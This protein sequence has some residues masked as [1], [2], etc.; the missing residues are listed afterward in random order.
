MVFPAQR[1]RARVLGNRSLEVWHPGEAVSTG[2]AVDLSIPGAAAKAVVEPLDGRSRQP[3]FVTAQEIQYFSLE[4]SVIACPVED[5]S[6][7][8]RIEL[9]V[10]AP[11]DLV[12][13]V[14]AV[15]QVEKVAK[16]FAASAVDRH[17]AVADTTGRLLDLRAVVENPVIAVSVSCKKIAA[18]GLDELRG[19]DD[20]PI[21]LVDDLQREALPP[22]DLCRKAD[23]PFPRP[24][25]NVKTGLHAVAAQISER[26]AR[27]IPSGEGAADS[28]AETARDIGEIAVEQRDAFPEQRVFPVRS[29]GADHRQRRTNDLQRVTSNDDR[30]LD[31]GELHFIEERLVAGDHATEHVFA[32]A[33]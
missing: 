21:I 19:R 9:A 12:D 3:A 10:E 16:Y 27:I 31:R 26:Q 23:V 24:A 7:G 4:P 11:Q 13:R 30:R 28:V 5:R 32:R 25:I 8:G 29:E 2:D 17:R 20:R 18:S 15:E 22:R 14:L 33:L 6:A 1:Q